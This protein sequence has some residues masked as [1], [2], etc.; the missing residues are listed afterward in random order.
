MM[1]MRTA[2]GE[3]EPKLSP[4]EERNVRQVW[5]DDN[6]NNCVVVLIALHLDSET[7]RSQ[8]TKKKKEDT[9]TNKRSKLDALMIN[10]GR[11]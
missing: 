8:G 5:T 7:P 10:N 3:Q 9:P 2:A 11:P 1:I 6:S 4:G